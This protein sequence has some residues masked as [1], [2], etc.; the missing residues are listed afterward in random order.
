M[1]LARSTYYYLLKTG[2]KALER[3]EK[4][5]DLKELIDEIH[6]KFP[7]YGYRMLREELK[8]KYLQNLNKGWTFS[9]HLF[10]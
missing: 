5:A 10:M 9:E 6:L 2:K 7:Y 8:R 3:E 1:S 4:E